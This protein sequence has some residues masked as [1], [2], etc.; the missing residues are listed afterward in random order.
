MSVVRALLQIH[1]SVLIHRK[2][3]HAPGQNCKASQRK[4]NLCILKIETNWN[5]ALR[6]SSPVCLQTCQSYQPLST[7]RRRHEARTHLCLTKVCCG[8]NSRCIWRFNASIV[9]PVQRARQTQSEWSQCVFSR[10]FRRTLRLL[11]LPCCWTLANHQLLQINRAR[12]YS[13]LQDMFRNPEFKGHVWLHFS[14]TTRFFCSVAP[15]VK[16]ISCPNC[17]ACRDS[18]PFASASCIVWEST[19]LLAK[20]LLAVWIALTMIAFVTPEHTEKLSSMI[21]LDEDVS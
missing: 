5:D 17:S 1:K 20:V 8:R 16:K 14:M 19:N 2:V 10:S 4:K 9:W 13:S 6:P 11:W 18:L 21:L 15:D 12:V 7:S 3:S